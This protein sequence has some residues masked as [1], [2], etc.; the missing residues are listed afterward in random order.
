MW[1]TTGMHK[2]WTNEASFGDFIISHLLSCSSIKIQR[3]IL[4]ELVQRRR[5]LN[6]QSFNNNLYRL[7][8]R[9]ILDVDHNRDIII[10]K[11]NL[12]LYTLFT[13]IRKKPTG[14]T[15]VMVLFDIPEKKRK[16]RSWLRMQL[17]M[18]DFEMLQQSVWLGKGPLP[19][20]F[21]AR[22]NLLGIR[23][24]V[25]ILKVQNIKK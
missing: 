24:C 19:A 25:K 11:K 6:K 9:G 23:E 3:D 22:L 5:M 20:E 12:K 17:R 8:R 7:K 10:N 4:Y 13:K 1:Y 21:S 18:W 14:S 15:K 16:I 2:H